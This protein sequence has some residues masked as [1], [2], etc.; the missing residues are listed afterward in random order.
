MAAQSEVDRENGVVGEPTVF[1]LEAHLHSILET[2]PD[3]MIVI[4]ERGLIL[5]FSAAAERMFGFSEAELLGENISTLM[6]SPDRERHDQYLEDYL[7]TGERRIIGIGRI[8]TARRRNGA[9]FPIDLHIGEARAGAEKLFTGFIRD[10]TERQAT[11]RRLH[12]LQAELAH[13]A[14]VT[15]MGTLATALAHELNQPLTAIANYVETARDLLH[16]PTNEL[17]AVVREALDECAAQSVRAGQIV[18]RLRDYI[19]R[20]EIDRKPESLNQQIGRAHV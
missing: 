3:A 10:L 2:V 14:R 5:S 18:R 15:A 9:V 16:E 17:L 4:D 20:G 19:S 13:V 12:D 7:A 8:T 1:A 6:P 11:Q